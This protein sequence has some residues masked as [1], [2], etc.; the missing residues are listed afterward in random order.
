MCDCHNLVFLGSKLHL[1][2][3]DIMYLF[4][5]QAVLLAL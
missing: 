4:C 2:F 1:E 5:K 3:A